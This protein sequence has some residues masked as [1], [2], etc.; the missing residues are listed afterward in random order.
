MKECPKKIIINYIVS[1][2]KDMECTDEIEA[3]YSFGSNY[4]SA[5]KFF[6]E[7]VRKVNKE[8]YI[9]IELEPSAIYKG[10]VELYLSPNILIADN[11]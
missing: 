10:D 1:I 7:T 3:V 5:L 2:Y 11:Y 6:K 8:Q 4:Q 9:T